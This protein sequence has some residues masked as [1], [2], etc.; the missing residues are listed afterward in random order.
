M[1]EFV[2]TVT[3][4]G[5][6]YSVAVCSAVDQRAL[7][8]RLGK[9]GMEPAIRNLAL[10]QVGAQSTEV[11]LLGVVG[12]M[13]SRIPED[14]F[15]FIADTLLYKVRKGGKEVGI[16][17]FQNRMQAYVKLIVAALGANF[18]DFSQFLAHFQSSTDT[19]PGQETTD[20]NST[21]PSTGTSGD[22]ASA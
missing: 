6:T 8:F 17:D 14:D 15:N 21:Q 13:L 11:I 2:K 12:T 1:S 7:L 20:Q 4:D 9:Y 10:A 18:Q 3:V 16:G 5:E 19:A 22:P